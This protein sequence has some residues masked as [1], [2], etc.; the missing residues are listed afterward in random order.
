MVD[1]LMLDTCIFDMIEI[2]A[3]CCGISSCSLGF[4]V[5]KVIFRQL[6]QLIRREIFFRLKLY[7]MIFISLRQLEMAVN[8]TWWT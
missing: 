5:Q 8:P 7:C 3:K 4:G 6:L 1:P 2:V